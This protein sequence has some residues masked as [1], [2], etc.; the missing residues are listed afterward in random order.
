MGSFGG[1]Y[2]GEKKKKKKDAIKIN[3]SFRM[4]APTITMPE[5]VSKNKKPKE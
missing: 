3:S 4:G 2:K 1:Y 5:I